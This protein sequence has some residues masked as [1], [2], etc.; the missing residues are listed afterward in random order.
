MRQSKRLEP[1][2]RVMDGEQRR[3]AQT[4]A[5]SERRVGECEVK[6]AELQGY[7]HSYAQEF[8]RHAGRGMSGARV[9]DFQTFLTR[10]GEAVRQQLEILARARAE[11]DEHIAAWR[12]ASQRADMVGRVV[13]GRRNEER[14][15]EERE[16]QRDTDER[17][18]R[19]RGHHG[20]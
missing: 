15:G 19:G 2:Q 1:V 11:R 4:V 17:A 20:E 9:R 10:L 3:R 6:L 7:Q 8:T 16:E 5:A 18:A 14:R 13:I 12:R